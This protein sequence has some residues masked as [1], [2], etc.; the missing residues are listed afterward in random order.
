VEDNINNNNNDQPRRTE[1]TLPYTL[2]CTVKSRPS[3]TSILMT[4]REE[5]EEKAACRLPVLGCLAIYVGY[6]PCVSVCL[7]ER[8]GVY[9]HYRSVS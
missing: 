1:G 6:V 4:E 9:P 2:A 5:K 7:G 3:P 8:G